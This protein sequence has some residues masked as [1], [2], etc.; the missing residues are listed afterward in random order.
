MKQSVMKQL[1]M[2]TKHQAATMIRAASLLMM[3]SATVFAG[4]PTRIQIAETFDVPTTFS[5][6][7]S[8]TATAS[9]TGGAGGASMAVDGSL[10]TRWESQFNTDPTTLTLDLGNAH[11]LQQVVIYWEAANAATYNIEGSNDGSN[12]DILYSFSGGTFDERTDTLPV[13]GNY[14]YVRMNGLTRPPENV[15]GYSI[16]EMQVF[17]LKTLNSDT[18]N[19]GVDD[20]VDICPSTAANTPVQ[21]NGCDLSYIGGYESPLSR[22][23]YTLAWQDEFNG[24]SLN[25]SDWTHE[26]G[27]G[28]PN[29]CGWGNNELEYYR[30]ENTTVDGGQLIIEAKQENFGGKS[31]TS[32][33]IKTQAKQSFQYGRID[34]RAKLPEGQGLWPALWMLGESITSVGWPR[35]GEIDIMEMVGGQENRVLGTVHW[36]ASGGYSYQGGNTTLSSGTFAD[37]F[38]VFSIVWT[39][40]AIQ[41]YLDDA[42]TPFYSFSLAPAD[43]SEFKAPFYFIFN[44]AVGGNLPGSPN[45][46]TQ[47]PQTMVVDYVRVFEAN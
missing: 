31:Y 26:I 43:R 32:S 44:V 34:I 28:C 10:S 33:R 25:L 19:D 1:M 3:S 46:S 20:S 27:T 24:S 15:Y 16:W 4:E 17:S 6:Q 23:G 38:H 9:S 22:P 40:N 45:A 36:Q 2:K 11:D 14:R 8:A 47:F 30:S 42:A 35:A 18:D 12:W 21:S 37:E 29:L 5:Q 41:W 39:A 13:S 7:L